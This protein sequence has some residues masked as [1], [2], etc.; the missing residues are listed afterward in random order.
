[1]A[2]L[3]LS[4]IVGSQF[5]F[6][7]LILFEGAYLLVLLPLIWR[8]PLPA[9][10]SLTLPE[11]LHPGMALVLLG[12][13][14]GLFQIGNSALPVL[15]GLSLADSGMSA[16]ALASCTAMIAQVAMVLGSF[17]VVP[18]LRKWG[19]WRVLAASFATLPLRCLL[20]ACLPAQ[21]TL[22][23]VELL[24]GLGESAQLL[25]IGST[26]GNLH[27]LRGRGGT[28]YG[29]V[30]M[31]QGLGCVASPLLAGYVTEHWTVETAYILL[32][33]IGLVAFAFWSLMLATSRSLAMR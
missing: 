20:A 30:M 24:H 9:P 6:S 21:A 26:I 29:W 17:L 25:A 27:R 22:L 16:P 33:T 11:R 12:I 2:G 7:A 31:L 10:P 28:H 32:G 13:T 4:G 8:T 19:A 15:L 3:L 5:G 14:L 1:V 23:P 18:A